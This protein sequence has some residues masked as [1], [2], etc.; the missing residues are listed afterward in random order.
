MLYLIAFVFVAGMLRSDFA[1]RRRERDAAIVRR[2]IAAYRA[3]RS[4]R[5]ANRYLAR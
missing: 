3:S 1:A 4:E 5:D 2:S